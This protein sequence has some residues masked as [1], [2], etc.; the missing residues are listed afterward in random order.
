M[1]DMSNKY[2]GTSALNTLI[3]HYTADQSFLIYTASQKDSA[4]FMVYKKTKCC[5]FH[6]W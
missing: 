3:N 1:T 6:Y 4:L 2:K 5:T